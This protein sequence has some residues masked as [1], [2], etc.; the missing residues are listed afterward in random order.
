MRTMRVSE[1]LAAI[2]EFRGELIKHQD[3]LG[4]FVE[5]SD[6][7]LPGEKSK[8]FGGAEPMAN[9]PFGCSAT[10]H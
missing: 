6:P 7:E 2:D 4:R 8:A 1:L 3:L 5:Q 10:I 9:S